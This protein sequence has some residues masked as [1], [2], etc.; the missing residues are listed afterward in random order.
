VRVVVGPSYSTQRSQA[1]DGAGRGDAQQPGADTS[2][3]APL[4]AQNLDIPHADKLAQVWLQWRLL[5]C[6]RS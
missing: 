1:Q 6:R 4:W 5:R 2:A 3:I